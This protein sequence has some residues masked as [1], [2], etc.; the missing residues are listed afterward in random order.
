[1]DPVTRSGIVGGFVVAATQFLKKALP[2]IIPWLDADMASSLAA[3][4]A[5][6]L[7]LAANVAIEL[8]G[9]NPPDVPGAALSGLLIGATATGGFA[10]VKGVTQK[11]PAAVKSAKQPPDSQ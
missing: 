8:L 4:V 9:T 10:A 3:F 11:L 5:I 6:A 7:G 1:M 2:N